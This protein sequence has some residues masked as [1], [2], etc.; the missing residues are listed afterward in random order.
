MTVLEIQPMP[1]GWSLSIS[2][3]PNAMLFRSGAAAEA[4]ARR[5]GWQLSTHGE[6]AKLIVR[7][8]DGSTGGRFV[9]PP[10]LTAGQGEVR[11]AA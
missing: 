7:L 1:M 9:F 3:V 4:A 10:A 5:L 8:R 2:G 6:P 11:R